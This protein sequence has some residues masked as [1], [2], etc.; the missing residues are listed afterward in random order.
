L[1]ILIAGGALSGS[2]GVAAS[3]PQG[4]A[5][6]GQGD[7]VSTLDSSD[8][9]YI[10]GARVRAA[11]KGRGTL[12][13]TL[14]GFGAAGGALSTSDFGLV[15]ASA[16]LKNPALESAF[17][18][19]SRFDITYRSQGYLFAVVP[20]SFRVRLAINPTGTT[21]AE[22]VEVKFPWY[23]FFLRTFVSKA[24]LAADVDAILIRDTDLSIDRSQ[25]Q[26]KIF[27]DV[28]VMLQGRVDTVEES[29]Q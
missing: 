17:I 16:I 20:L 14:R 4:G 15:G 11:L 6:V 25:L 27:T 1:D 29:I 19:L 2:D 21:L 10:N 13:V 7:D 9:V 8:G 23:S 5:S 22:R 3:A 24:A 28:S 12:R 26:A 18:S